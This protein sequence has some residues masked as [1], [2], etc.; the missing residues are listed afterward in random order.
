MAGGRSQSYTLGLAE[1]SLEHDPDPCGLGARSG[2]P[3]VEEQC[4]TGNGLCR[5]ISIYRMHRHE[6][7]DVESPPVTRRQCGSRRLLPPLPTD[8]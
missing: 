8:C 5:D 6:Q 4:K 7:S 3:C 1:E 2:S